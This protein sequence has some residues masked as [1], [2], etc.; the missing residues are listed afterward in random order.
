LLSPTDPHWK[1]WL[2]PAEAPA[3]ARILER[4]HQ[5][6][7][8]VLESQ[9]ATVGPSGRVRGC[10]DTDGEH[11]RGGLST[12]ACQRVRHKRDPHDKIGSRALVILSVDPFY[13]SVV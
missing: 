5:R 9:A 11:R 8:T 7:A 6:L 1:A 13:R 10:R 4:K 2:N 3:L 12:T